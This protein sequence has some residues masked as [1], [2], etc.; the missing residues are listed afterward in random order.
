MSQIIRFDST[1]EITIGPVVDSTDGNTPYTTNDILYTEV[2]VNVSGV[3]FAAK[4]DTVDPVHLGGGFFRVRLGTADTF[5]GQMQVYIHKANTLCAVSRFQC[6]TND[7]YTAQ[8]T[9]TSVGYA[10][11]REL[12]DAINYLSEFAGAT[13]TRYVPATVA[14]GVGSGVNTGSLA[15]IHV[16]D[17]NF[18]EVF[19]LTTSESSITIDFQS[20]NEV[21]TAVVLSSIWSGPQDV[22]LPIQGWDWDLNAGVGDW[23]NIGE[24]S[25]SRSTGLATEPV[26]PA[27]RQILITPGM[28]NGVAGNAGVV[29][30]RCYAAEGQSYDFK[31]HRALLSVEHDWSLLATSIEAGDIQGRLPATLSAN[32]LMRSDVQEISEDAVA[33][34][35]LEAM[36][37]GTGYTTSDTAP[38]SRSQVDSIGAS[39]GGSV[40]IE[41]TEDNTAGSITPLA[42]VKAWATATGTLVNTESEDG[43]THDFTKA[44]FDIDH[45]Y[46]YSIGG[47]RTSTAVSIL[48][49][50]GAKN[51]TVKVKA[52]NHPGNSWDTIGTIVGGGATVYQNLEF[53]LLGKH[54]GSGTE[55]GKTYIRF[56]SEATDTNTISIDKCLIS[57]V[58][59][60]QSVGYALGRVWIDTNSTVTETEAFVNGVADNPCDTIGHAITVA[61]NVGLKELNVSPDST[62]TLVANLQ[63]KNVYGVGY[64]L[65][66]GGQDCSGTHFYHA[67]CSGTVLSTAG[68]HVDI[69]DSIV[70]NVTVNDSHFTNC[71]FTGTVTLDAVAGDVKVVNSRSGIAGG[72]TP[73]FDFG[74][75][76]ATNH[77][78]TFANWQNGIEIRNFNATT[79]GGTDL[80]SLSGTGQ[81]IIDSTCDGGTIHLRGQW[82]VTNNSGDVGNPVTVIYDDVHSDVITIMEDTSTTIPGLLPLSLVGGRMD[83]NVSAINNDNASAIALA[84]STG[85]IVV[86]VVAAGTH[87]ATVFGTD[88]T[89]A[90]PDHFNGRIVIFTS[91][92]L[93]GQATDITDYAAGATGE[94][95]VTALTSAPLAGVAF[96]IV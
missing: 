84:L 95:T 32:S 29:R 42:T 87:S 81:I 35:N 36:Y 73:I 43:V 68:D 85:Q 1:Q 69:L 63:N 19:S 45:V 60:G 10:G 18:M 28:G 94:I 82:R 23:V 72:S 54:T 57:A 12:Y 78:A 39:S 46:G 90:V 26:K 9:T 48:V 79:G 2:M 3:T 51:D 49:S 52:F 38:A 83:S 33:A 76:V 55:I 13:S 34:D 71:T 6:I 47:A 11:E 24:I 7:A 70:G 27:T 93:E 77:N 58:N 50:V 22:H 62:I 37:D 66:F 8:Y 5:I 14:V 21:P 56:D 89:Q 41:A 53:A 88:L 16:L 67:K 30:I 44:G 64:T 86:G 40:N 25:V 61:D 65:A 59:I 75:S 31:L 17:G 15:D 91:G 92:T 20:G 4:I 74:V 96:V 80:L